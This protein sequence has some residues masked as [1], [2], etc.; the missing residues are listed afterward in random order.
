MHVYTTWIDGVGLGDW[1]RLVLGVVRRYL[2]W[3]HDVKVVRL[4]ILQEIN[5]ILFY[6]QYTEFYSV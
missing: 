6:L 1:G 5:Y 4:K 2:V 3:Y